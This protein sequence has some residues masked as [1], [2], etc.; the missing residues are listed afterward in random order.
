MNDGLV[1][2]SNKLVWGCAREGPQLWQGRLVRVVQVSISA[3][4]EC[5]E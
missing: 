3:V 2:T 4:P 5:K 1:S